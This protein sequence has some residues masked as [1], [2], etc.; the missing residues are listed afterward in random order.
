MVGYTVSYLTGLL[1][2]SGAKG[3][4]WAIMFCAILALTVT[5]S[6]Y[7]LMLVSVDSEN[8]YVSNYRE[9][10]AIPF[11][12][13]VD[14]I[15]IGSPYKTIIVTLKAPSKFGRKIMFLPHD[16]S[17]QD[18]NSGL[19]PTVIELKKLINDSTPHITV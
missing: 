13:I 10:I 12:G 6:S 7:R 14:A 16:R 11:S 5:W 17:A 18:P 2:I 4:E 1:N 15:A 8:L 9:E 19:H 3:L